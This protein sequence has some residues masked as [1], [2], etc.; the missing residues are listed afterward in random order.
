M[1][2]DALHTFLLD[3]LT[4]FENHYFAQLHRYRQYVESVC[5][6]ALEEKRSRKA[7]EIFVHS[8]G[9]IRGWKNRPRTCASVGPW[10]LWPLHAW[11]FSSRSLRR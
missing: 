6:E 9:A 2:V 5:R 4:Q 7:P 1:A 8:R 10:Q 3:L 11:S